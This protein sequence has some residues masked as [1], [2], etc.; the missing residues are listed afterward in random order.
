MVYSIINNFSE[1]L[2]YFNSDMNS[3]SFKTLG[4]KVGSISFT[5]YDLFP[6]DQMIRV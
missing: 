2:V 6:L 1:C 3:L 4:C 5:F